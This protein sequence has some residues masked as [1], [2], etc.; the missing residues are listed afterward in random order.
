MRFLPI[1]VLSVALLG[2][3]A[4]LAGDKEKGMQAVRNIIFVVIGMLVLVAL[5]SIIT[6]RRL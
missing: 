5:F 4:L 6:A 1:V 2:V 3:V